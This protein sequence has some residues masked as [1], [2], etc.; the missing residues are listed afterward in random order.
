MYNVHTNNKVQ[1]PMSLSAFST[2]IIGQLKVMLGLD[3]NWK[4]VTHMLNNIST[5][6]PWVGCKEVHLLPLDLKK[7]KKLMYYNISNLIFI[8]LNNNNILW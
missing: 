5:W 1:Y 6:A 4:V 8:I 7:K 3:Y 2:L